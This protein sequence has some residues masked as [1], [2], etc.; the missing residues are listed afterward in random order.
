MEENLDTARKVLAD[1][2]EDLGNKDL[3]GARAAEAY[4]TLKEWPEDGEEAR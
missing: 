4:Y 1:P 3:A 2:N